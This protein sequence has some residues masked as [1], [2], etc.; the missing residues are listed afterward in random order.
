MR[1]KPATHTPKSDITSASTDLP[2][3]WIVLL[4]DL[5]KHPSFLRG[6][7]CGAALC[8]EIH[9]VGTETNPQA[10]LAGFSGGSA[11]FL[12]PGHLTEGEQESG[13]VNWRTSS[14]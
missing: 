11:A 8:L 14:G 3:G 1:A 10:T 5:W 4:L 6:S 2:S 13:G 7:A 12:A 9:P